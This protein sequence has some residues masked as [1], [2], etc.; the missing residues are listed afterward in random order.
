MSE[1]YTAYAQ[2]SCGNCKNA[3]V[4]ATKNTIKCSNLGCKHRN[5]EFKIP[6]TKLERAN[7]VKKPTEVKPKSK[8]SS[9]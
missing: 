7:A 9:S 1:T 3:M 8:T 2:Y 5:I 4:Y 6:M